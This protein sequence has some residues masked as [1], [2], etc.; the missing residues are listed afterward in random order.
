MSTGVEIAYQINL[1]HSGT[2]KVDDYIRLL[3]NR[4]ALAALKEGKTP[5]EIAAEWES[6]YREIGA[7]TNLRL[8]LTFAPK[9]SDT[10]EF[11]GQVVVAL[12]RLDESCRDPSGF[13]F[14]NQW[15]P[16]NGLLY[17]LAANRPDVI[18]RV[19]ASGLL[20]WNPL[21]GLLNKTNPAPELSLLEKQ[22]LRMGF[23]RPVNT[24]WPD[25][26]PSR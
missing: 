25:T 13:C 10:G 22:T 9:G 3:V 12:D 5:S 6:V 1:L 2:W 14:E 7:L 17:R 8:N 24:L 18:R 20:N 16:D 21:P 26:D 4:A 19:L 15:L 11:E 23:L